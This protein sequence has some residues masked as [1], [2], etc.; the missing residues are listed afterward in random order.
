MKANILFIL[1]FNSCSFLSVNEQEFIA[2]H[3]EINKV[4]QVEVFSNICSP[5][6]KVIMKAADFYRYANIPNE[7][8]KYLVTQKQKNSYKIIRKFNLK[9]QSD[10]EALISSCPEQAF[11]SMSELA[12]ACDQDDALSCFRIG[13]INM[14]KEDKSYIDFLPYFKKSCDL[15]H[16]LGCEYYSSNKKS[17]EELL[18]VQTLNHDCVDNKKSQSCLELVMFFRDKKMNSLAHPYAEKACFLKEQVGCEFMRAIEESMQVQAQIDATNKQTET[19]R[20]RNQL[21]H[22]QNS[23]QKQGAASIANQLSGIYFKMSLQKQY[24]SH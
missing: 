8:F 23:I 21:L 9:T 7:Y 16:I 14:E 15:R 2:K 6:T 4:R 3:P 22:E 12:S 24:P 18:K 13:S 20:E 10:G 19:L 17:Y 1:L 5:P 11:L